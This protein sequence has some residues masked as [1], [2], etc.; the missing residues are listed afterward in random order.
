MLTAPVPLS[1]AILAAED[2]TVGKAIEGELVR[3]SG[4]MLYRV[5]VSAQGKLQMVGVDPVCGTLVAVSPVEPANG[6][7]GR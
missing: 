3:V 5:V 2:R 6:T 4:R 7:S 1:Q